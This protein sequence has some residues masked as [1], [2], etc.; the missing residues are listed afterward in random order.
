MLEF[1]LDAGPPFEW[2]RRIDKEVISSG[3]AATR[4]A[5]VSA[6]VARY[7]SEYHPG[8]Q[9]HSFTSSYL[10]RARSGKDLDKPRF[11]KMMVLKLSLMC[12]RDPLYRNWPHEK[13]CEAVETSIKFADSVKEALMIRRP[14]SGAADISFVSARHNRTVELAGAYGEELIRQVGENSHGLAEAK[15]ALLH[16]LDGNN[17]DARYWAGRAF[18]VDE[19]YRPSSTR[20]ELFLRAHQY[21]REYVRS[22]KPDIAL[23]YLESAAS[24][25]DGEAA[26][27]CAIMS[28]SQGHQQ[29][30][31]RWYNRAAE[32]GHRDGRLR[33]ERLSLSGG[34]A[35]AS[36]Q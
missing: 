19:T 26:F 16:E 34:E 12:L 22:N 36:D 14:S 21:A 35:E 27:Q 31:L 32:L 1:S 29:E 15:L 33:A 17:D 13:C 2:N 23:L 25:G 30:A 7:F 8:L 24:V 3:Q 11:E 4:I 9:G 28:D 10:S 5:A 20:E 18:A 6:E